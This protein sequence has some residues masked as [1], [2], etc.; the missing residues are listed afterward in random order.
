MFGD[1]V[2]LVIDYSGTANDPETPYF[3]GKSPTIFWLD[4]EQGVWVPQAGWDNPPAKT[5][6]VLLYH[7]SRYAMSDGTGGWEGPARP[8]ADGGKEFVATK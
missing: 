6:T 8:R 5:Y 2:T 7:F 1:P 4:E 3:H